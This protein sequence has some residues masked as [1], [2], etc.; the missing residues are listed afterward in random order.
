MLRIIELT[1]LNNIIAELA[2]CFREKW[3]SLL[4]PFH[5][6]QS[7]KDLHKLP[8]PGVVVEVGNRPKPS[9]QNLSLKKLDSAHYELKVDFLL[10]WRFEALVRILGGGDRRARGH[11]S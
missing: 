6:V 8:L 5:N 10:L 3:L 7:F 11:R 4:M 2:K 1:L 9:Y